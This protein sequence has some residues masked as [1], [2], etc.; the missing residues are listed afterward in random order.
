MAISIGKIKAWVFDLIREK[1][2]WA[3]VWTQRLY[4]VGD[5]VT[6]D[7]WVVVAN[8]PTEDVAA[9]QQI[10]EPEFTLPEAPVWTTNNNTSIITSGQRYVFTKPGWVTQIRVWAPTVGPTIKYTILLINNTNPSE[11]V[12][13]TLRDPLL[14]TGD[15]TVL[16]AGSGVVS[17]GADIFVLLLCENSS[18]TTSFNHDWRFEGTSNAGAP[19][20]NEWNR[21]NQN[22]TVR[23]N[24]IDL[25]SVDQSADLATIIPQSVLN[26]EVDPLNFL[27][28]LVDSAAIDNG[29]YFQYDVS[30]I[31]QGGAI[32]I[33][34]TVTVTG[35]VPIPDPTEYVEIAGHWTGNQPDFA[36]VT[37]ILEFDG[38]NQSL[39]DSAFGVDIKFQEANVS[40]DWDIVTLTSLGSSSTG[41]QEV[42]RILG[43]LQIHPKTIEEIPLQQT[44]ND[45]DTSPVIFTEQTI[46]MEAGLYTLFASFKPTC[47]VTNRSVV[48]ALF[49]DNAQ[50]GNEYEFEPKDPSDQPDPTRIAVVPFTGGDHT[51]RVDFGKRPGSG[52]GI[53]TMS[54]LTILLIR[55]QSL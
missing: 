20:V 49:V 37:G 48:V 25:G 42:N 3:N 28:Y 47:N 46:N 2:T 45:Y 19:A 36:T 11:P 55:Q 31:D 12:T 16:A 29:T 8:K 5:Q 53:V 41:S 44:T 43:G 18:G 1:I 51:F 10:G 30:L 9:P 54:N 17:P 6:D 50:L 22:D 35:T 34:D 23:I 14:V 39:P 32:N 4:Q 38:V 24:D 21:R 40:D 33:N 7:G 13:T 26:F 15:W 52:T 27:T